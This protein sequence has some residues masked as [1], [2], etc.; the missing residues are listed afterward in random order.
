MA[1]VSNAGGMSNAQQGTRGLSAGDWIRLQRLRGARQN[2]YSTSSTNGL[3]TAS[4]PVY[5]K[6]ISPTPFPQ[7]SPGLNSAINVFRSVGTSKIR[8]PASN[9]V[10]FVASQNADYIIS[11]QNATTGTSIKNVRTTLCNCTSA[12][13]NT[14]TGICTKCNQTTHVRI[15]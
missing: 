10:D 8:R 11:S 15:M 7:Y 1:T 6:D 14:K 4:S 5:N 12:V 3:L 13:V 2:G 9:W